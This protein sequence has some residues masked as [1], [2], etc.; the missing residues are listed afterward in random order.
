MKKDRAGTITCAIL[1]VV[2][3]L[4]Q[5]TGI[6]VHEWIGFAFLMVVIVHCSLRYER[7]LKMQ[8]KKPSLRWLAGS[9]LDGTLFVAL[10]TCVLS[11]IMISGSVM[12]V[13]GFY[14]IGYYTWVPIHSASAKLL[15]ACVVLHVAAHAGP[16]RRAIAD[17]V[18]SSQKK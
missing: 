12:Q 1:A 4:P 8:G 14:S 15:L 18:L 17:M 13:F 10:T 9:V 7:F 16:L 11:G 6:A 3:F 5:L 2:V